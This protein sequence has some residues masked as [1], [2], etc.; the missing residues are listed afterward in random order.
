MPSRSVARS[1]RGKVVDAAV[2]HERLEADDAAT[3][4]AARA[5]ST[6]AR[7]EAAP[8]REVADDCAAAAAVLRL[9]RLDG[10]DRRRRIERHVAHRRHAARDGRARSGRPALPVGASRLVEVHV[11]IDDAGQDEQPGRVDHL[12][13]RRLLERDDAAVGNAD[14]GVGSRRMRRSRAGM[15][16]DNSQRPIPDSQKLDRLQCPRAAALAATVLQRFCAPALRTP[17]ARTPQARQWRARRR[18]SSPIR[19]DDG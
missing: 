6:L 3:R 2:A 7:H 19:R 16:V 8:E 15:C 4:P 18:L 14:S 17:V 12:A 9:E 5:S 10:H 13:R 1:A 11:R